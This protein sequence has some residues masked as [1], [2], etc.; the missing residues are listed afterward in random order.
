MPFTSPK[1]KNLL[2]TGFLCAWKLPMPESLFC[3]AAPKETTLGLSLLQNS[4]WID[5][6]IYYLLQVHLIQAHEVLKKI[7]IKPRSS[8]NQ[9]LRLSQQTYKRPR[10]PQG[11]SQKILDAYL[12]RLETNIAWGG[13]SRNEIPKAKNPSSEYWRETIHLWCILRIPHVSKWPAGHV[14]I[15]ITVSEMATEPKP[16]MATAQE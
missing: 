3:I 16:S 2:F 9:S 7:R 8:K 15:S 6:M 13:A 11:R 10:K 5:L 1:L 4:W 14:S 12:K